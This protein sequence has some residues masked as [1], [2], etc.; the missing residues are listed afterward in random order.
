MEIHPIK[1]V[2]SYKSLGADHSLIKTFGNI[3]EAVVKVNGV[4]LTKLS[5]RNLSELKDKIIKTYTANIYSTI[6]PL[7]GN[8]SILGNPVSLVN[9]IG[10]GFKEFIELPAEGFSISAVEGGKGLTKG[11]KSLL[12]NTLEG[13][14]NSL[15]G[16]SSG[17]GTGLATLTLD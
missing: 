2:V 12:K 13:T 4:C 11:T 5:I 17:L 10:T 14:M 1:G 8:M 6:L 7:L 15:G 3:N 16:I 9:K